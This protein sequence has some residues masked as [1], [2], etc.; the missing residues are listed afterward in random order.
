MAGQPFQLHSSNSVHLL[1]NA[2]AI[3]IVMISKYIT[4]KLHSLHYICHLA[5][6]S[7]KL[8]I[9]EPIHTATVSIQTMQVKYVKIN[10]DLYNINK[11]W[12][13]E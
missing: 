1:I 11:H 8:T 4:D 10:Y 12:R 13:E 3:I 5:T 9:I 6:S 7:F 2:A